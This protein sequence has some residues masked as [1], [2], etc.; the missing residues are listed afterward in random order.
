MPE[1]SVTTEQVNVEKMST[2]FDVTTSFTCALYV[3]IDIFLNL[4][5]PDLHSI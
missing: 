1:K 3:F 5:Q 2:T 4:E